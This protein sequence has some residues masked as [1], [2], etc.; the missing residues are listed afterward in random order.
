MTRAQMGETL[1][2]ALHR[3]QEI[4][5]KLAEIR[6]KRE[7]KIRLIESRKRKEK[8]AEEKLLTNERLLR[9]RQMR[10][11]SLSLD[12]ASREESIQKHREALNKAKTNKEY[13]GILAAMNTEKAD[14]A[15]IE[16]AVLEFMEE[17]QTLKDS[18]GKAEEDKRKL[19]E[20]VRAAEKLLEEYDLQR[21]E[22]LAN[23]QADRDSCAEAIPPTTL[24]SF[25]RIAQSLEGEAMATVIKLYPKRDEYMCAGCN[26]TISLEI[27]NALRSR[28]EVQ[29]CGNCGRILFYDSSTVERK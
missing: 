1:L 15:K 26:M 21:R 13:A 27:V 14:A 4:E 2:D 18:T 3:L 22:E 8:Q 25:T 17:I 16:T 11:D 29:Q 19:A 28:D 20:D 12:V 10:L 6:G 24:A 5:L 23:L 9:E 7:V